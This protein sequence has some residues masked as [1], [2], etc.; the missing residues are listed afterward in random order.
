MGH[1][2]KAVKQKYPP[3]KWLQ[4]LDWLL[5]PVEF[6]SIGYIF[7]WTA[8]ASQ[9][10]MGTNIWLRAFCLVTDPW[11]ILPSKYCWSLEMV[12]LQWTLALKMYC[13]SFQVFH[14]LFLRSG[15]CSTNFQE[16]N[17]YVEN[18]IW[19]SLMISWLS[20]IPMWPSK[21][22]A[23]YIYSIFFISSVV[24]VSLGE[25]FKAQEEC[26]WNITCIPILWQLHAPGDYCNS[27][28]W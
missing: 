28:N 21:N 2:E 9:Y 27:S 11:W 12:L 15:E 19:P 26:E 14:S 3:F 16:K 1:I 8:R 22:L 24:S 6:G 13:N 18:K 23:I 7:S 25:Q 10:L 5:F 20:N 4:S 17:G